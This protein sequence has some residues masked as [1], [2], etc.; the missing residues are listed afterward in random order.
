LEVARARARAPRPS[1]FLRLIQI[2]PDDYHM[3]TA[4]GILNEKSNDLVSAWRVEENPRMTHCFIFKLNFFFF[5]VREL[6]DGW[7]KQL[8]RDKELI[9]TIVVLH[10]TP[11]FH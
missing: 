10:S 1:G 3:T 5:S 4:R 6:K 11:R 2:T 8:L 9:E 7:I